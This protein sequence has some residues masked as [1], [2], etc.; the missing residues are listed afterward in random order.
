MFDAYAQADHF[1]GY[2]DFRLL[3]RR[4]LAVRGG[5]GMTGQR[6]GVSHVDHALEEFEGVETLGAGFE[7]AFHAEGEQRAGFVAEITM[8]HG[9]ER[10]VG[11]SGVVDPLDVGMRAKKFG[12]PARVLDVALDTQGHGFH[13]L[14]E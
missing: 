1:R 4:E 13:A 12:D 10:A 7:S 3:F 11:K 2:A 9:I 8:G 5:R 6:L 14:Q